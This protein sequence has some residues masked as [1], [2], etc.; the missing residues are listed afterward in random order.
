MEYSYILEKNDAFAQLMKESRPLPDAA[1]VSCVQSTLG[2]L[3]EKRW[4]G[5]RLLRRR[6][7]VAFAAIVALLLLLCAC[8]A[9]AAV[10]LYKNVFG[11]ASEQMRETKEQ[12]EA[13]YPSIRAEIENDTSKQASEMDMWLD[14]QATEDAVMLR[15]MEA[16][17]DNAVAVGQQEGELILSE[18]CFYTPAG[19][20]DAVTQRL[21]VGMA[22]P[23]QRKMPDSVE[24]AV[25]GHMK[26]AVKESFPLK[27]NDTEHYAVYSTP[28]MQE[29]PCNI[30][31]TLSAQYS[32]FC[33]KYD[34]QADKV[35]LPK[36][37][38]ERKAWLSES[39]RLSELAGLPLKIAFD[40]APVTV[41]GI[42]AAVK[43]VSVDDSALTVMLSLTAAEGSSG[44]VRFNN[45][46]VNIDGTPYRIGENL[47]VKR[48]LPDDVDLSS[49]DSAETWWEIQ[50]PVSPGD[51][52]GKRIGFSVNIKVQ[53]L[54]DGWKQEYDEAE[55]ELRCDISFE[56]EQNGQ[57]LH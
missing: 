7:P 38:Q 51:L 50:L 54:A 10:S 30:L 19:T 28:W 26:E 52:E 21:F 6:R 36:D 5:V 49:G 48:V 46:T 17:S 53:E 1:F 14:F 40:G 35:Q 42:T 39:A 45:I 15:V 32:D 56:R 9:Y 47:F 11:Q 24:I 34:R 27:G 12:H 20:N 37:E 3:S 13:A 33:F 8:T 25:N 57:H 31:I 18:F 4:D 41:M 2:G 43:D 29:L 22:A 23:L 44:S 16:I 55:K